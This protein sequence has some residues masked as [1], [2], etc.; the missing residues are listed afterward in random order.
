MTNAYILSKTIEDWIIQQ[1]KKN[2]KYH[3]GKHIMAWM[4]N[5]IPINANNYHIRRR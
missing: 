5:K 4:V 2:D 1:L 3:F